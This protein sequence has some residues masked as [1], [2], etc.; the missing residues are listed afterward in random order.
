M[1]FP[2]RDVDGS[3]AVIELYGN[4]EQRIQMVKLYLN[5]LGR[6][7]SSEQSLIQLPD[8]AEQYEIDKLVRQVDPKADQNILKIGK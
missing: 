7:Y 4:R 5:E 3:P 1:I 6:T 8:I 2:L